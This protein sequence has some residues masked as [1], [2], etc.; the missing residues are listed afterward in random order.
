MGLKQ[1]VN[2]PCL[3]T[4]TILSDQPP[5]YIGLYVDDFIYFSQSPKVES[6][7][8]H[9]LKNDMKML[10]EFTSEPTHFLGM[11]F[12]MTTFKDGVSVFLFQEAAID[13][14]IKELQLQ[15][16]VTSLLHIVVDT[17][18]TR[19]QPLQT[20]LQQSLKWPPNNCNRLL[21]PSIGY[22]VGPD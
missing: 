6:V 7:F 2:A 11:K 22:S 18:S 20:F 15:D 21:G 13:A 12:E 3:F 19:Y 16:A 1:C 4:G 8:K 5:I 17:Q 10:V 14:L 9:R